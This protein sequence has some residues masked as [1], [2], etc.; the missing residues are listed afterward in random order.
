M[1]KFYKI[2][3][4]H[5]NA[6]QLLEEHLMKDPLLKQEWDQY[7]K[8][9]DDPRVTRVGKVLR[10]LSLDELPQLFNVLLGDM[11]LV[12]PRPFF[13]SQERFYGD[14]L[15]YYKRVR[16]GLTG[17]WQVSGRNATTFDERTRFDEYYVRNWSS[18]L[19]IYI[20]ARTVAVVLKNRDAY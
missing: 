19:D 13:P 11:S 5:Q 1:F 16:P 15:M 3:T 2:R 7:Q 10:R 4:M 14:R 20:L 18:W 17:I 12:G 6:D 9:Q 8:L